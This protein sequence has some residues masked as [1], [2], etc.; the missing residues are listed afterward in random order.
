[1]KYNTG[2]KLVDEDLSPTNIN[3]SAFLINSLSAS[4]HKMIKHNLSAALL[5]L[6]QFK[7]FWKH[8]KH[9]RRSVTFSKVAG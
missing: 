5:D 9:S 7:Q 4:P 2:L 1:M 8:E 3:N 6:V